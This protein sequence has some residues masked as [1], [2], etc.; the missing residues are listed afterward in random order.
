MGN[1][2]ARMAYAVKENEEGNKFII[3]KYYEMM[4]QL[5]IECLDSKSRFTSPTVFCSAQFT[6]EDIEYLK[7]MFEDEGISFELYNSEKSG[8]V[9]RASISMKKIEE[10]IDAWKVNEL[11]PSFGRKLTKKLPGHQE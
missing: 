8:K 3:G 1:E 5:L 10:I 2:L 11:Q 9:V 7:D 4:N 6:D